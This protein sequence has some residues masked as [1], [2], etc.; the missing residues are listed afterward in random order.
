MKHHLILLSLFISCLLYSCS[1]QPVFSGLYTSME[2]GDYSTSEDTLQISSFSDGVTYR[3]IRT[4]G[5]WRIRNGKMLGP[6]RRTR[7][8]VGRLDQRTGLIT[9]QNSGLQLSVLDEKRLLAGSRVYQK[10]STP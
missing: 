10:I 8:L 6:E 7:Q 9:I 5:F 3:I 2:K 1:Q 4:S